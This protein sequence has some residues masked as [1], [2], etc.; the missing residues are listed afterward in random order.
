MIDGTLPDRQ[1]FTDVQCRDIAASGF[2]FLSPTPPASDTLVVALG[3]PP[4][5][6]Y[7]VAQIVHVT[8]VEKRGQRKYVI[9]CHYVGRA[10]Y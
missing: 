3:A 2:S 5:V 6:T 9:G 7:L 1:T 10:A 8:R 4:K